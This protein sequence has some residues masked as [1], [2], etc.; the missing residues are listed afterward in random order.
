M[1]DFI[2]MIRSKDSSGLVQHLDALRLYG[3]H[4]QTMHR[5][6]VLI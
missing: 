5:L 6:F 3:F 2:D 1:K 4:P